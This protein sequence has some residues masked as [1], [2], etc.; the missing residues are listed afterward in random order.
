[1]TGLALPDVLSLVARALS[2][3]LLLQSAGLALF[4]ALFRPL[5]PGSA[6]TVRR[7]GFAS[8][9]FGLCA[10]VM[11]FALEAPRMAGTLGGF[12]DLSLQK[13]AL[14][15]RLGEAFGLRV[16]GLILLGSAFRGRGELATLSGVIG[17]T[18][19]VCAFLL[20]GHTVD[21]PDRALLGPI[22]AV[23]VL[24]VAFWFGALPALY[25]ATRRDS[26]AAAARLIDRFSAR[27][28]WLVPLILA[29]GIAMAA[30][31]A[32]GWTVFEEPY[33]ELLLVKI[34]GFAVLM[35]LAAL[36]R[37]RLAPAVATAEPNALRALR[38]SVASE[39]ILIVGV[40]AATAVMTT[41]FS[42]Q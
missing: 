33:G 24:I 25:L 10:V 27:A 26:P 17:A 41:L 30:E 31:L 39:Y 19:A 23:H 38:V 16:L 42:P 15:S 11:Q 7:M 22:L 2:F 8:S 37:W 12:W 34:G 35:G 6:G 32:A 36:N 40:L 21:H 1:M 5:M 9:A 14:Y 3:V 20:T 28:I 29:A 18:L 13:A 4:L